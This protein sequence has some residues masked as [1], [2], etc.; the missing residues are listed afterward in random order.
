MNFS[1]W[2]VMRAFS[3]LLKQGGVI[4][5]QMC[6]AIQRDLDRQEK[7]WAERDPLSSTEGSATACTWGG[8]TQ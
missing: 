6:T 3:L 5:R 2:S 1:Y 4:D 7:K 8:I